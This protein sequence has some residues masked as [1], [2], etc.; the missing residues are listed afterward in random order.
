MKKNI[1]PALLFLS[2]SLF[3]Q[4]KA[5]DVKTDGKIRVANL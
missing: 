5:S 4:N 1:I 3:A 2:I